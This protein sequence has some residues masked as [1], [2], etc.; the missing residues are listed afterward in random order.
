MTE[1]GLGIATL[2]LF[3]IHMT[4][5]EKQCA[6]PML[7]ADYDATARWT[8]YVCW[9]A[10]SAQLLLGG[11]ALIWAGLG[12]P[13]TV[14]PALVGA[15]STLHLVYAVLF[16][17]LAKLSKIERGWLQLGQWMAFLPLGVVGWW[18]VLT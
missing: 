5:G 9:H 6:R 8:M 10:V 17:G 2:L 13:G 4:A 18:V 16:L 3:A 12:A 14:G 11:A 7:A 15:I 1:I